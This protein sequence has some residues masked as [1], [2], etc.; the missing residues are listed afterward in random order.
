M[1]IL[2]LHMFS[3]L[4]MF[5]DN[6]RTCIFWFPARFP[7]SRGQG[8]FS[9]PASLPSYSSSSINL[10]W[11]NDQYTCAVEPWGSISPAPNDSPSLRIFSLPNLPLIPPSQCTEH[12]GGRRRVCTVSLC[13]VPLGHRY[14]TRDGHC[15]TEMTSPRNLDWHRETHA[16]LLQ[17]L[18]LFLSI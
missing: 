16:G 18:D 15:T 9:V 5:P 11:L 6:F 3:P 8:L 4:Y 17:L 10:Q 1:N 2:P 13:P 14:W 7:A 12:G